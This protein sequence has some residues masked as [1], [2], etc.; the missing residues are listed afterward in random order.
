MSKA[1]EF[2]RMMD[3]TVGLEIE[4][5][6]IKGDAIMVKVNGTVYGYKPTGK[7]QDIY[8]SFSGMLKYSAGKA[9]AFLKKNSTQ[10]SGGKLATA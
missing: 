8:K 6:G 5:N 10:I 3:E 4:D 9:F 7:L 1:S 2:I